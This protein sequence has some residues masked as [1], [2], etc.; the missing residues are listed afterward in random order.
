MK[1]RSTPRSEGY[2]APRKSLSPL[3][4]WAAWLVIGLCLPGAGRLMAQGEI[5]ANGN[6]TV[7]SFPKVVFSVHDR[8]PNV[9]SKDWFKVKEDGKEVEFGMTHAAPRD[10]GQPVSILVLW[11]YLPAKARDAQNKYFRQLIL[12]AL[13]RLIQRPA[14][15]NVATFAWTR[16]DQGGKTLEFLR[17]T[18]GT[19]TA[20][21]AFAVKAAKAPSGK[22]IDQAHGSELY[23]ALSEGVAALA[24]AKFPAKALIVLSAEFPN[25]HNQ[26]V[27]V[28]MVREEARKADVAIYNLRYKQMDEK[29][30]LDNLARETYGISYEVKKDYLTEATDTMVSFAAT[31]PQRSLG[32]NYTFTYTSPSPKDGK[33]HT[34]QLTAGQNAITIPYD[35]PSVSLGEWI[36]AN[37]ALFIAL[38][39]VVV[40]S[41]IGLFVWMRKRKQAATA[42]MQE[43]KRQAEARSQETEQRVQQQNQQISQMQREEQDRQRKAQ[44]AQRK[45]ETER[46]MK[47]LLTEMYA[48]GRHPRVTATVNGQQVT[49]EL[50]SPV[51]TVGRDAASDIQFNI[52]TLSRTHFQIVYQ[53]GKYM[54]LDLG[55]TNGT[56]LNGSRVT[57][58]EL[59]HG[60]E[61]RAGDTVLH[62]FI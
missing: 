7:D 14:E 58:A 60:D 5:K 52:P 47:A 23:P 51:T 36:G 38:V 2:T 1:R 29:Y 53:N 32:R 27:D 37:V 50:P 12:N 34:V 30:R 55:S 62:F 17:P 22:G 56:L 6:P 39:V 13:P 19:D 25:I 45:E 31:S 10:S 28:S 42:R 54:V 11:E 61:I 41:G 44:D 8:D 59:R 48:N 16:K 4:L 35:A 15:V 26:N 49:M 18:F 40:G 24:A 46:E 20:A 21:L 3:F 33:G 43:E 9:H 57:S